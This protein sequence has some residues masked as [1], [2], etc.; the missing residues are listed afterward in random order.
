[1]LMTK[2]CRDSWNKTKLNN[3]AKTSEMFGTSSLETL[4]CRLS[5]HTECHHEVWWPIVTDLTDVRSLKWLLT[6]AICKTS[7]YFTNYK[8][9][10]G[11]SML[12]FSLYSP[13]K[14]SRGLTRD[15][16]SE[17]KGLV[18]VFSWA[19]SSGVSESSG[20]VFYWIFLLLMFRMVGRYHARRPSR[21]TLADRKEWMMK[22]MVLG[23][24]WRSSCWKRRWSWESRKCERERIHSL[25]DQHLCMLQDYISLKK[26]VINVKIYK[27]DRFVLSKQVFKYC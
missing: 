23:Q 24:A 22:T 7:L 16:H 21:L 10:K 27:T 26:E 3:G 17:K 12:Q 11:P 18:S 20:C 14:T 6:Y 5:C 25:N 8:F 4:R 9:N 15:H 1:M 13:R 19:T 2:A